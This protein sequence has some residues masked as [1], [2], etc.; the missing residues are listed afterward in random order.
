VDGGNPTNILG[1]APTGELTANYWVETVT[2]NGGGVHPYLIV[3][4]RNGDMFNYDL[5]V[6]GVIMNSTGIISDKAIS[7]AKTTFA[8][9]GQ[10]G[11]DGLCGKNSFITLTAANSLS[12][13]YTDQGDLNFDNLIEDPDSLVLEFSVIQDFVVAD[14]DDDNID[15]LMV[16]SVNG[17]VWVVRSNPPPSPL[18]H[19]S[20]SGALINDVIESEDEVITTPLIILG[21]GTSLMTGLLVILKKKKILPI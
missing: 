17:F 8:L 14:L 10:N 15:D 9:T 3:E 6:S 19:L 18:L 13:Y 5:S 2:D 4:S 7:Y 20:S 12:C 11:R 1:F 16:T 21:F